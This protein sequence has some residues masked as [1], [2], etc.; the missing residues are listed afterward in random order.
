MP[1]LG[2]HRVDAHKMRRPAPVP[3]I[4]VGRKLDHVLVAIVHLREIGGARDKMLLYY[5]YMEGMT[6]GL[7]LLDDAYFS[8]REEGHHLTLTYISLIV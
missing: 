7:P 6:S 3:R 8:C 5:W 2:V 1:H 4:D